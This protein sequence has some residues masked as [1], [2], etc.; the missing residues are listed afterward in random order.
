MRPTLRPG[1]PALLLTLLSL[2]LLQ[3]PAFAQKSGK[4]KES[5]GTHV[6]WRDPG[7]IP[8]RDLLYG[9]GSPERAPVAPFTFVEEVKSGESPK[10]N[11]RDARGVL[12]S[13]K[14]GPE[15]QAETVSTRLAWLVG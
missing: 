13:V 5:S 11:V 10:F 15:A 14:L 4:G 6:L 9:P 1:L 12:W 7:D 3:P 2:S 8:S